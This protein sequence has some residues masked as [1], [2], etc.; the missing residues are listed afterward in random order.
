MRLWALQNCNEEIEKI[1]IN[2]LND[3]SIEV[4]LAGLKLLQK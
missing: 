4:R 2:S 3:E 1:I